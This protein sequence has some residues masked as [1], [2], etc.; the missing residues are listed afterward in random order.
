MS[1]DRQ[2]EIVLLGATGY[3]G[4]LTAE[5][6][7]EHVDTN[8]KWAIAGRNSA[9]LSNLVGELRHLNPDR[10]LPA[11]EVVE[12]TKA[13]LEPLAR[14]TKI[15]ITTVGPY[16]KYGTPTVEACAAAGTHYLDVTGE[17]PWV[18]E[19]MQ[20]HES[21]FKANK[22]IMISQ[23]GIDSAP[24]DL[25]VYTLVSHI[26]KTLNTGVTTV[27]NS[28]QEAAGGL[29]GGT[30]NT[31]ITLIE[32]YPTSHMIKSL[33]PYALSPIPPPKHRPSESIFTKLLGVRT[34]E[35]L[36]VLTDS[37][38]AA[39]DI[40]TVNRSWG[41]FDHGQWYGPGFAFSEYMRVSN[42]LV[43]S[44]IHYGFLAFVSSLYVPPIRW[45][46]KRWAYEPGQGPAKEGFDGHKLA[47][48]AIAK[49]DVKED[50]ERR[51]VAEF[52]YKGSGYYMTGILLVEAAMTILRSE[53]KTPAAKMGGGLMTPAALGDEYVERVKKAGIR[54]EVGMLD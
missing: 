54:L 35:G 43:G 45:L 11:V 28:L 36:G 8:L 26:R 13:D 30:I 32:A 39:P 41:L 23:C 17:T 31:A 3:T 5:Y 42:S 27:I 47:Y 50:K 46:L 1:S 37:P 15:L 9:K 6:I 38:Q 33:H 49:A 20:K 51:A 24:S 10:P 25:L 22:K 2:Y 21:A 44:A 4:K 16:W 52:E 34:I 12:Q 19:M 7:Q 53:E 18:Y 48:K 40:A 14:K 29:S